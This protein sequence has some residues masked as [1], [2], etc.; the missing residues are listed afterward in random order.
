[1]ITGNVDKLI[2]WL[3]LNNIFHW[4][5][6]LTANTQANNKV[7]ESV[8]DARLED[9]FERM[10]QVTSLCANRELYIYA[11]QAKAGNNNNYSEKWC[12]LP[13]NA[14]N[15]SGIN[16]QNAGVPIG[17][18]SNDEFERRL[19]AR[20]LEERNRRDREEFERE[21][22]AFLDEKKEY[23]REKSHVIGYVVDK[24]SPVVNGILG[25]EPKADGY[26]RV[27]GVNFPVE[28]NRIEAK[29]IPS[30]GGADDAVDP[31]TVPSNE[32][33]APDP[34]PQVFEDEEADKLFA[35]MQRYKEF[36]PEYLSV[37]EKIVN[38]ATSGEE[39]C[40][41]GMMKFNYSQLKEM[42]LKL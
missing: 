2:E 31:S 35:L 21:R 20:L 12:N 30:D 8:D 39:V 10:R 16:N 4:S 32:S 22:K 28:A 15:V 1:M 7:F 40:I 37:I 23:E 6:H 3:K 11:R 38:I 19:E 41:G 42:I 14:A 34:E 24:L 27:A 13:E 26:R 36:D 5:L 9:E 29:D 33:D 25:L 18:I 17:Y